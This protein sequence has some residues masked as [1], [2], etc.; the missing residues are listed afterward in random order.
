MSLNWS[1]KELYESFESHEFREDLRNTS[2][3]IDE[4]NTWAD[5]VTSN[6]EDLLKK[7]EDYIEKTSELKN[8]FF[9]LGSF[10][11]LSLSVNTKNSEALKASDILN[12]NVSN[13]A[14]ANA[15]LDKWLGGIKHIDKLISSSKILK[16]HEF[17][18]REKIEMNKYVLSDKEEGVIAKMQNTGSTAWLKLKDSLISNLQVEI[19]MDGEIK[20]LPLT[21]VLTMAY[22]KDKEIRKKAYEAEI[23]SYKKVEDGVAAALN[24]IKGEALT[25]SDMRGYKSPLEMTLINS[26]MEEKTLNAMMTAMKEYLPSFRKYLRKKAEILGYKNGLPFYELYAPVSEGDMEF[27]CERG[28]AFVEDNFRTFSKHLGDFARRAYENEWIDFMPK[29]GKVGGGFC[30]NL[31][32]IGESRILLNYGNSFNDVVTLAHELGHGFHGECLR[33]EKV[34]NSDYPM[35]IAETA[36]T[37]C[38]TIVKKAG[39]KN[40]N[41]QEA[42]SILETEISGCTQVIVD[43]YSRFLFES[44]VFERRRNGALSADEIKEIMIKAQKEAYGDGLDENYLHPYMWTWKPHYYYVDSN[45]YNF[46]YA[47]GLLFAKGLYAKYL[48][49]GE[50]FTEDYEKLLAIT[51]RNK[52]EDVAKVMEIDITNVDF[53]RSSLK[54]IEEDIEEFIELSKS[55]K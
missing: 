52:L 16:E 32:F 44:E 25:I 39:I 10:I 4:Y 21:V 40:G 26:R 42:F 35:P 17:F 38:E 20:K 30:E 27:D 7:I 49:S 45:F 15:K 6:Y 34:L 51:G 24:A 29:E 13:M 41:P 53:W 18:L 37:F 55:I 22:D 11:E 8:Y 3:L 12:Q 46:P 54:T 5:K 28:K 9:K 1:L 31:H 47:F 33:K 19:E 43:I 23:K 2:S 36:S 48:N 14:E 50:K